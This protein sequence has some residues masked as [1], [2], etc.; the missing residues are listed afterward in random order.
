MID[1]TEHRGETAYYFND[2]HP[3]TVLFRV[4]DAFANEYV[5]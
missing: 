1:V 3:Y 5:N 2:T 4:D